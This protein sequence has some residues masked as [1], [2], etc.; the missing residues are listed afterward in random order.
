MAE[1]HSPILNPAATDVT[2]GNRRNGE[3]RYRTLFDLVPVAVYTTDAE[4]WIQ[5]FNRR[6]VE[7]WG[8]TPE[9]NTERYCGSFQMFHPDGTLMSHEDCPMAKVLRGEKLEAHELEVVVEQKD[10]VR[11]IVVVSPSTL[12]NERGEIIGAINCFYDVTSRKNAEEALRQSDERFRLLVEGAREYAMF[13]IDP[14]N[15]ITFWS[16]GAACV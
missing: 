7:L 9:R 2:N 4:G 8:R 3:L 13:L 16:R 1:Q 11:R 12:K 14:E 6:A 5:E 15:R 10:G